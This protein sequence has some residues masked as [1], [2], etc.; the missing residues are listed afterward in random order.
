MNKQLLKE[1]PF[2]ISFYI[3][4][5]FASWDVVRA[6]E[7][8]QP[9]VEIQ[10]E[11]QT[12]V[13]EVEP[14]ITFIDYIYQV[15]GDDGD[16]AIKLL[17]ECENKKLN[18]EAVNVNKNGSTDVGLF[19]IN[20]IHGYSHEELFDPFFNIDVAYKI[21]KNRGWSAWSCSYVLGVKSFWQ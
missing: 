11:Q 14:E 7:Q 20:S 10:I 3:V 21:F 15:F 13:E 8:P 9:T 4:V 1:L 6:N 12:A 18:P 2:I 19:Q 5:L 16:N 17:A